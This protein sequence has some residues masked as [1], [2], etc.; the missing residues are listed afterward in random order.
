MQ[1]FF[2]HTGIFIFGHSP[3][4]KSQVLIGF[5][6]G[7]ESDF[8]PRLSV[9]GA[10]RCLTLCLGDT[11]RECRATDYSNSPNVTFFYI[12]RLWHNDTHPSRP[13]PPKSFFLILVGCEAPPPTPTPLTPLMLLCFLEPGG[14]KFC[15]RLPVFEFF[16]DL[17]PRFC[18][19]ST[20]RGIHSTRPRPGPLGGRGAVPGPTSPPH[21][22][23][24]NPPR[25]IADGAQPQ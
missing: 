16:F 20:L 19:I 3:N 25:P 10:F 2:S 8:P 1:I 22:V 14:P 12:P 13:L 24:L 21:H 15:G 18:E 11:L 23:N 17:R 5:E 9:L 6:V 7:G 4:K